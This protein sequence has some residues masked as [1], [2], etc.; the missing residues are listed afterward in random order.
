[1]WRFD[2]YSAL[3]GAGLT[4]LLLLLWTLIREPLQRQWQ[5]VQTTLRRTLGRATAGIE[6]RYREQVVRWAQSVH[7]LAPMGPLEQFFVSPALLPPLPHPNPE[8]ETMP[9]Q[10]PIAPALLL[11]G[12]QRL[13][14][15]GSPG[16]G[17]TTLL[18]YLALNS[19]TEDSFLRLPLYLYL[20]ALS[21]PLRA[22]P[23]DDPLQPLIQGALG[24]IGAPFVAGSVLRRAVRTGKALILADGWDE[25]PPEPQAQ[26]TSWLVSLADAFPDNF[27]IVAAGAQNYAPLTEVGFVPI[28]ILP[29]ERPQL[30][31]FLTRLPAPEQF[32]LERATDLL[33]RL[34]DRTTSLLDVAL[35]A[36]AL[37]EEESPPHRSDLY[38]RILKRWENSLPAPPQLPRKEARTSQRGETGEPVGEEAIPEEREESGKASEELAVEISPRSPCRILSLLALQMQQE[39]R[40]TLSRQELEQAVRDLIFPTPEQ[41]RP[42]AL[43]SW[44]LKALQSP[45]GAGSGTPALVPCGPDRYAFAHP[46]WQAFLAS[47]EIA[48]GPPDLLIQH[49]EDPRWEPVVDFYAERGTMEPIIHAWFS[50]PD[51]L[52]RTRL[53][54]AARWAALTPSGAPWRN[55]VMALLGRTLLT[56]GLLEPVRWELLQALIRTEDPGVPIF[57][58]HALQHPQEEIRALAARAMGTLRERADLSGLIKAL[59]DPSEKVRI[60]AIHALG[61]LGTPGALE[62]LVQVLT[63]GDDLLRAEAAR[64]L[65]WAG[66]EGHKILQ[67]AMRHEDFLVRR[68]AAYGLGEIGTLWARE[69]LER[70]IREDEQWV[71]RSAATTALE[72]RERQAKPLP[73]QPPPVVSDMGWLIAWAADRGEGVGLGEAAFGPLLRALVEGNVPIRMAAA[74]TLGL[75]GRP[76]HVD[77]LQKALSDPSPEVARMAFWALREISFRYGLPIS[78][79]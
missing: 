54:K 39:G 68:A 43:V 48:S 62:A 9:P 37:L 27:W 55:G 58:R 35:Y 41:E 75:V 26:A 22:D 70:A 69:M 52:W 73:P 64:G 28:R 65:A 18:A 16:S 61:V 78:A 44:A 57:L 46:L 67:E 11:Q 47:E 66:E 24:T 20:P 30:R 3:L 15:T 29:W 23:K 1:M 60:A 77:A 4:L 31:D 79:S 5:E 21:W 34:Y 33:A 45:R 76:E 49:L 2:P 56:P 50:R 53:C 13:V 6:A 25:L 42:R 71:V 59:A 7:A 8:Q 10:I 14:V 74:Q 38:R 63:R 17:R 72:E 12:H 19:L 51:D 36:A 32:T 40:V